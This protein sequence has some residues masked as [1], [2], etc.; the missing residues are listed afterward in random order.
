MVS[1][2]EAGV[3]L[4]EAAEELP[5]VFYRELNGGVCLLPE[6]KR[7]AAEGLYVLGEYHIHP[8]MGRYIVIYYGS[9]AALYAHRP[10]EVWREELKRT[11]V[12]E[13]THHMESL[14]GARDLEIKDEQ[15]RAR[16]R[17]MRRR[18]SGSESPP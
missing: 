4:D 5:E 8:A 13:F 10:P 12:H 11:L 16:Y 17:R 14:A 15:D 2:E 18:P 1:I 7:V 6:V 9:F 3:M